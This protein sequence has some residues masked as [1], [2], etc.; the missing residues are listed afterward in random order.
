MMV[1]EVISVV[2]AVA[3]VEGADLIDLQ[4]KDHQKKCEQFF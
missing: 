3:V 4:N 2:A 1:V